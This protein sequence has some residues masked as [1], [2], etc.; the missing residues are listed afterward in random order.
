VNFY[1]NVFSDSQFLIVALLCF[2]ILNIPAE[3]MDADPEKQCFTP[4]P[5]QTIC[6][7]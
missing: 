6:E 4:C 2:L 1:S 7:K 3:Y 5:I